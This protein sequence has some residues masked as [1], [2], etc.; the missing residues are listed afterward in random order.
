[1]TGGDHTPIRLHSI[2]KL[3]KNDFDYDRM[4]TYE[5]IRTTSVSESAINLT[6]LNSAQFNNTPR[7][8]DGK[9]NVSTSA[10]KQNRRVSVAKVNNLEK[11]AETG[12]AWLKPPDHKEDDDDDS[13]EITASTNQKS[14]IT[15]QRI[16]KSA[17]LNE[18]NNNQK[19]RSHSSSRASP[20]SGRISVIKLPRRQSDM[21]Q[22]NRPSKIRTITVINMEKPSIV[23]QPITDPLKTTS[24]ISDLKKTASSGVTVKKLPR[25]ASVH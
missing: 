22:S 23:M 8:S 21:N 6:H 10:A 16:N 17:R 20:E 1:M 15:V 24:Q 3:Q 13:K 25:N 19:D 9:T 12:N 4:N 11:P 2:D 5:S 18:T 14:S 7:H